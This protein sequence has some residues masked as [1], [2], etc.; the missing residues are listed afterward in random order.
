MSRRKV[1]DTSVLIAHWRH[2][3]GQALTSTKKAA[4]LAKDLIRFQQI[5]SIFT[6]TYIEF[7]CGVP[8]QRELQLA[9]SFLAEFDIVDLGQVS[10]Q[11]W[12]EAR[13]LAERVPRS[14]KKRQ[15]GDCLIRA[16]A[17]RLRYDVATLDASFPH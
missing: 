16:I 10:K 8:S 2:R 15:L 17:N 1:L 6:P 9:R 4:L 14:G 12:L 13:R 3:K 11:D 5:K 7:V